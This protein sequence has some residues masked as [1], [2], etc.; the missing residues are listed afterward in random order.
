MTK[1]AICFVMGML[2]GAALKPD[3]AP[4]PAAKVDQA[5][6]VEFQFE[7]MR[8]GGSPYACMQE[9]DRLHPVK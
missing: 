4:P 1:I 3:P 5:D 7:C 8:I 2:A 9:W 6:R